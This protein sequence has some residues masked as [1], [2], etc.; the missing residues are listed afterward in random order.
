MSLLTTKWQTP[1]RSW[2]AGPPSSPVVVAWPVTWRTTA[3][4]VRNMRAACVMT[5]KSVSAGA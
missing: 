3:G 1:L 5:T 2:T 4:P